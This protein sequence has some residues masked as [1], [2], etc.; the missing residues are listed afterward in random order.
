MSLYQ[1]ATLRF[2]APGWAFNQPDQTILLLPA[3]ILIDLDIQ[4]VYQY[5]QEAGSALTLVDV[6]TGRSVPM[7]SG[8]VYT[9][10]ASEVAGG[11]LGVDDPPRAGPGTAAR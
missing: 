9:F 5:H 1:A 10:P 8:E 11:R 7:R 3:D 2:C 4:A 6:A